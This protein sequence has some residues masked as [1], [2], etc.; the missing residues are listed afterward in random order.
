MVI[1][2]QI[3]RK[4]FSLSFFFHWAE[5]RKIRPQKRASGLLGGRSLDPY[6]SVWRKASCSGPLDEQKNRQQVSP[7]RAAGGVLV[8]APHG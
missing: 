3:I 5:S 6:N 2:L 4:D 8:T 7:L 1:N